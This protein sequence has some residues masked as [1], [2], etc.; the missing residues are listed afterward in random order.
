MRR[1]IHMTWQE[2]DTLER[3]K[4]VIV[5]PIGS[6]EQHGPLG[7]AGDLRDGLSRVGDRY[8]SVAGGHAGEGLRIISRRLEPAQDLLSGVHAA[9]PR[10]QDKGVD[11]GQVLVQHRR[12]GAGGANID[13]YILHRDP[14]LSSSG[15]GPSG[16]ARRGKRRPFSRKTAVSVKK[17]DLAAGGV[18]RPAV[19]FSENTGHSIDR[20]YHTSRPRA[21]RPAPSQNR[22]L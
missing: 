11:H 17:Q 9:P 4:A 16:K 14:S 8:P 19:L 10:G 20:F 22:N 13:P 18:P 21:S 2:L 7:V 15:G 12:L 6:V 1:L 3:E 5:M